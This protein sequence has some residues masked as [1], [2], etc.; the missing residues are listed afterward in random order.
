[1]E[2]V[3]KEQ[4]RRAKEANFGVLY[5]LGP[6]GLAQ[7]MNVSL[8]EA[9]NFIARYY[10]LYPQVFAFLEAV[11]KHVR[12]I[13]Y[14]QTLYGRRR[15]LP[16]INSSSPV[17]RAAAERAAINMPV[18]GTAADIIKMAMI[19]IMKH[20]TLSIKQGSEI[21][22]LLQVHDELLF[23]VRQNKVNYWA[24]IIKKEMENTAKLKVQLKVDAKVGKNWKEMKKI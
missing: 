15:Y 7:R 21:K 18:Q 20:E 2:K 4:R 16:E 11:I 9:Q 24:Q 3:N 1:M 13:G 14:A 12:Q 8:E 23:E 22:M 5:G 19:R 6:R 17:V 10:T